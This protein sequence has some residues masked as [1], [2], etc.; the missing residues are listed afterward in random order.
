MAALRIEAP[1]PEVVMSFSKV[2]LDNTEAFH[3]AL[4]DDERV[5]PVKPARSTARSARPGRR[6]S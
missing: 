1:T 5:A 3:A 6:S 2:P 4:P